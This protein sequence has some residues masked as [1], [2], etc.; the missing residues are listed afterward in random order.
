MPDWSP[1]C[2]MFRMSAPI[3]HYVYYNVVCRP[4][5]SRSRF[6]SVGRPPARRGRGSEIRPVSQRCGRGVAEEA[7]K[8]RLHPGIAFRGRPRRAWVIG[9]G[10]DV[11]EIVELLGAYGDDV[12]AL[13][14]D[15]P[16]V[17]DRHVRTARAYAAQFAGEIEK[18]LAENRRPPSELAGLYPFSSTPAA[19]RVGGAAPA[20]RARVRP[21]GR[22]AAGRGGAR[23]SRARP[24]AGARRP[25]RRGRACASPPPKSGSLSLITCATSPRSFATGPGRGALARRRDPR[26]RHRPPRV[27][28]DH[29]RGRALPTALRRRSELAGP[30]RRRQS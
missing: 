27:R 25:G 15:H 24:G 22:A 28:P 30:R 6:A 1:F 12:P 2:P 18:L 11:W 20:R 17:T 19:K 16:L 9:S 23:G 14:A 10:L 4:R 26:L 7:A 3:E 8:T 13:A 21:S 5:R 29:P